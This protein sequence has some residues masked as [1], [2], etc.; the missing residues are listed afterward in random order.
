MSEADRAAGPVPAG[1][2]K[3]ALRAR[4][5][6]LR[7]RLTPEERA[8][9]SLAIADR[10]DEVPAFRAARVVALYAPLGAEVDPVEAARRAL[11]RGAQVV[12]PRSVAGT[13][14]LEFAA[15][16]P[17]ALVRGPRGAAEPPPEAPAV[18]AVRVECVVLPGV[19]FSE[20][21]L[22]LGRGAGCYDATLAA[23]PRAARVGVAYDVQVV[24]TL[25]RE[26]HDAELDALVTESRTLR[27]ARRSR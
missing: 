4:L 2:E 19:G 21:G 14:R 23:M 3:R 8:A 11:A 6:G 1:E 9:R 20:D 17:S 5:A 13:R 26:P 25:P 18:D 24:P 15:A 7:T 22:R 10:I 27:F 12:F 16:A